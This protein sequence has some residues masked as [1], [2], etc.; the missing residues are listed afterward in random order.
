MV[1]RTPHSHL[2]VPQTDFQR[3]AFELAQHAH[4]ETDLADARIL[5]RIVEAVDEGDFAGLQQY[6]QALQGTYRQQLGPVPSGRVREH[7]D[8]LPAG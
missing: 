5:M 2:A 6:T 4:S 7:A 1:R 3:R 8:D